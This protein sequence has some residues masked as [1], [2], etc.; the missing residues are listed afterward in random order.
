MDKW[1]CA[2]GVCLPEVYASYHV[3][4]VYSGPYL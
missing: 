4:D 3:L 1:D 2:I